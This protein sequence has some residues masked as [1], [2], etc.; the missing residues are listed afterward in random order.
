M[1]AGSLDHRHTSVNSDIPSPELAPY[2]TT[3]AAI[4]DPCA[5]LAQ[6]PGPQGIRETASPGL[7]LDATHPGDDAT[8]EGRALRRRHP[9]RT[10]G[11]NRELAG[12]YLLLA[13]DEGS[14]MSGALLPVTGGMPM[15]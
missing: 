7:D 11:D 12:A 1:R 8:R 13:S 15:L 10:T 14:Y 4:A 2:A 5:S 3:K 6:L 9:T